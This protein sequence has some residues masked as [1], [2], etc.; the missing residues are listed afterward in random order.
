MNFLKNFFEDETKIIGLCAFK[1][2]RPKCKLQTLPQILYPD[3]NF[4]PIETIK[5]FETN[6]EKNILLL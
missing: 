1:T 3:Y 2:M 5:N 4:N 6:F